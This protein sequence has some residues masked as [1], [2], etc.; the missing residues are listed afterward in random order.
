MFEFIVLYV[1]NVLKQKSFFKYINL[2]E[3]TNLIANII[4]KL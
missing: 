3:F 4:K 2:L 1:Y